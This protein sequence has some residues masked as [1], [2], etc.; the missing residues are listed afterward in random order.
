MQHTQRHAQTNT[1]RENPKTF[2]PVIL[3][4]LG[5]IRIPLGRYRDTEPEPQFDI[6]YEP[7]LPHIISHE[8][9]KLPIDDNSYTLTSQLQSFH[10]QPVTVLVR[11]I[12]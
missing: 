9:L 7:A 2:E 6:R 3:Q 12:K 11:R 1:I 8:L 4:P 10:D 5:G